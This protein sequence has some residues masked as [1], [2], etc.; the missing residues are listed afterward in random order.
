V[1]RGLAVGIPALFLVGILILPLGL[2]GIPAMMIVVVGAI[3]IV[4]IFEG[5]RSS[6]RRARGRGG[7]LSRGARLMIVGGLAVAILY[8]LIL[9]FT[10]GSQT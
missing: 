8:V 4:V 10:Q 9:A 7:G 3:A 5:L 2:P 1:G 6:E